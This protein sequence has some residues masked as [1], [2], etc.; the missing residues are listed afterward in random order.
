MTGTLE[1]A[2]RGR[3]VMIVASTGGHLAEAD[4]L[5]RAIGVA[6]DSTWVTFENEQSASL[7]RGRDALYV[8]YVAPRDVGGSIRAYR[9]ISARVSTVHYDAV[10][11]TGAAVGVSGLAAARRHGLT[12]YYVESMARLDGPS[13]T[14]RLVSRLPGVRCFTQRPSWASKK[15]QFDIAILDT[16]SSST[17]EATIPR[18]IL[19]TLGTIKPYRFDRLIDRLKSVIPPDAEVRWQVGHTTRA[20]L[21]GAMT[22]V[23][24]DAMNEAIEWADVVVTHSGVG[25][26]LSVLSGSTSAV[27]IPR[28]AAH[29]EHVDDHQ[30]QIASDVE[31]RGLCVVREADEVEWDDIVRATARAAVP[32]ATL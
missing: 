20:D 22:M 15:W 19:V 27:V 29:Q 26:I 12:A 30:A 24:T 16:W 2:M 9:S 4:M 23:D 18:K 6:D 1:S 17:T 31:T 3:R 8:P 25:S 11:S 5:A 10:V 21:P 13:L 32:A 14:G 7:L 28:R